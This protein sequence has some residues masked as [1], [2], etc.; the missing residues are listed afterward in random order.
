MLWLKISGE[1]LDDDFQIVGLPE[2]GYK[3]FLM[4]EDRFFQHYKKALFVITFN[5]FVLLDMQL[6]FIKVRS[7]YYGLKFFE[8]LLN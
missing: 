2:K 1:V 3:K 5:T 7:P 8:E 4:S 6:F